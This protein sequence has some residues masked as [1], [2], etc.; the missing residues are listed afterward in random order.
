MNIVL[1]ILI[2]YALVIMIMS[3]DFS[4]GDADYLIVLGPGLK[5]NRETFTMVN[6]VDRAALYLKKNREC[7]AIVSGGIT[8]NNTVSEAYVM[9]N[10]LI[11][12]G[13]YTDRI[14]MED[15]AQDTFENMKYS[16]QLIETDKKIVVCTSD[17][18]IL[19]SKILALKNGYR[20]HSIFCRTRGPELIIH[21][22]LEEVLII[23]D[24]F[25]K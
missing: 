6:R 18:H 19:R 1:Y 14:I 2:G 4:S 15:K 7:V 12:R 20:V 24:L 23:R 25:R 5:D 21:L 17:Y 8:D 3:Y 11:E 22:L 13:I 10:L 16:K 9:R